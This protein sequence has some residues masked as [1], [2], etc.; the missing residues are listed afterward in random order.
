VF[1]TSRNGDH[2][3]DARGMAPDIPFAREPHAPGP[4]GSATKLGDP[5]TSYRDLSIGD[6]G[7]SL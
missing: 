7:T 2:G 6:A 5:C 4:H 1:Y 3:H